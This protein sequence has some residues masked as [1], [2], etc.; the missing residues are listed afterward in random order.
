[1]SSMS[2]PLNLGLGES[3]D[4]ELEPAVWQELHKLQL[5]AKYIAANLGVST[6]AGSN[7]DLIAGSPGEGVTVQDYARIQ[8]TPAFNVPAGS[9]LELN[10]TGFT[11]TS[12]ANPYPVGYAETAISA[13]STGYITLL[14]MVHYAPGG[15]VPGIKYYVDN[16]VA[17]GITSAIGG[18]F[19]GQ[20][21][22]TD[23]LFFDPQRA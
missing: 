22:D 1:M 13:G 15:L 3:P 14:G 4:P 21:F 8:I 10:G 19:V 9:V 6:S 23:V 2:Y 7:A 11:L 17:G 12:A 20:A 16:A 5:A 18:R